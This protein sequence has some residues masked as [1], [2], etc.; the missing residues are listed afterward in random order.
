MSA[1]PPGDPQPW[2]S[3][4]P[5]SPWVLTDTTTIDQAATALARLE[6]WLTGA[7]PAAT[8]TCA[9]ALSD[10]ED[11]PIGVARWVGTLA[12]RLRHRIHEVDSWA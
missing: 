5:P 9:H 10:G 2:P 7:D 8:A 6:H 4:L 1:R 12:D 3:S 11:D